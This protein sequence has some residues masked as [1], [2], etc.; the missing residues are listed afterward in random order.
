MHGSAVV[1]EAKKPQPN[2][3]IVFATGAPNSNL[4]SMTNPIVLRKPYSEQDIVLAL[5]KA[6]RSL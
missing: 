2:L 6:R 5:K 3:S 4:E 1:T